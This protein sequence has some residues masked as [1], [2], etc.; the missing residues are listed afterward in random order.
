M[1]FLQLLFLIIFFKTKSIGFQSAAV[2]K[3]SDDPNDIER[4]LSYYY[5]DSMIMSKGIFAS[6]LSKLNISPLSKVCLEL[7]IGMH[8]YYSRSN[9]KKVNEISQLFL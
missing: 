6:R 3:S 7:S 2:G 9:K 5:F 8:R 1:E 4:T